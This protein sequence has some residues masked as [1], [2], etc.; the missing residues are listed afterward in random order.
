[1]WYNILKN[2]LEVYELANKQYPWCVNVYFHLIKYEIGFVIKDNKLD[3]PFKAYL[4]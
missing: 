3:I 4:F 2:F 1:M